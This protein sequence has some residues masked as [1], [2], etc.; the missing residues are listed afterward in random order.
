MTVRGRVVKRKR[1]ILSNCRRGK[2]AMSF[3]EVAVKAEAVAFEAAT[4]M[5]VA[6]SCAVSAAAVAKAVEAIIRPATDEG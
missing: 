2:R 1:S 6:A 3:T 5:F 4:V